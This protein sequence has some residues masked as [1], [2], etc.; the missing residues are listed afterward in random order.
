MNRKS[1]LTT[2]IA[3]LFLPIAAMASIS[4]PVKRYRLKVYT[5]NIDGRLIF[6]QL[7]SCPALHDF[8][9]QTCWLIGRL[10]MRELPRD[11]FQTP[12][13]F[14]LGKV[15]VEHSPLPDAYVAVLKAFTNAE[16]RACL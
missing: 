3:P 10:A 11:W 8:L 14:P 2:L 15:I 7:I 16:I 13:K 4:E 1:F 6:T 12:N 9:D 5:Y